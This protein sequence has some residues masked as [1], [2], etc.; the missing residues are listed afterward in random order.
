MEEGPLPKFIIS[1]MFHGSVPAGRFG[2]DSSTH[3]VGGADEQRLHRFEAES[4]QSSITARRSQFCPPTDFTKF[5]PLTSFGGAVR[6]PGLSRSSA[7]WS[8][9]LLSRSL[10]HAAG[11]PD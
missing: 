7:D 2:T 5:R 3:T 4:Q 11:L 6:F 9:A 10:V 8:I 1:R